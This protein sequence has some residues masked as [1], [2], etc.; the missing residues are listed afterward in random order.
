MMNLDKSKKY[1]NPYFG[2]V[3]L[4]LVLLAA[5]YTAGRGLGASGAVKSVLVTGMEAV[6]P[7]H[8]EST[9][10]YKEYFASHSGNPM[11]SWLVFEMLGLVV[12]GFVSG[13]MSGRLKFK[14]EHSPKI[15]SRK[16][17]IFAVLG[18]IFFGLGSQLGRGCTS[19][20]ALSGMA[21]LS[22]GGFI[23]MIFIFGTAFALAYFARK[24]WI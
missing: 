19:G 4:G 18:G 9:P 15:T 8:V 16:R 20:A 22:L 7:S 17:I 6:A 23:T 11:K 2:G 13:A 14:V 12:G 10:F 1:W 21:V 5:I 3:M 24:L